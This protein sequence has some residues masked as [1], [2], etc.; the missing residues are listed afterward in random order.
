MLELVE[1]QGG[2]VEQIENPDL[3]PKAKYIIEVKSDKRRICK[4]NDAEKIGECALK[5]GAG[6]ETMD[7]KIDL[8]A[9][10]VLNKKVND[11]VN[12]GEYISLYSY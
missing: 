5:L 4:I 11:K 6:R 7:S 3:L 12:K 9:G 10:I 1:Y 8:S 2:N